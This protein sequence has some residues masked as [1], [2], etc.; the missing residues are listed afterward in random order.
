MASDG[1][2]MH[3]NPR[4]KDNVVIRNTLYNG[5]WGSEERSGSFPFKKKLAFEMVINVDQKKYVVNII[6]KHFNFSFYNQ[7]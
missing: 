5:A 1:I 3:I 4:W 7:V 6:I 2:A